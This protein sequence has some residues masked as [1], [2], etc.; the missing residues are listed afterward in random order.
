MTSGRWLDE[1]TFKCIVEYAPL[2]SIDLII[3]NK[4]GE[5]LLGKRKNRPAR[6]CLFVPGGRI[7]KEETISEAFKR[8]TFSE[9]GREILISSA[10]FLGI[11]EHFYDDSFFGTDITTHYIVLA[12]K[13][14]NV[15][16]LNLPEIQ[17]TEYLWL[18]TKEILER[19]DVHPYTKTYFI[20][21]I[22]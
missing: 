19:E 5:I 7:L 12:Y 10:R 21:E 2:V 4:D 22:K 9:L 1:K 6:N 3:E 17:H 8:I 18:S 13:L 20:G 11:F 15:S 16:N 14:V